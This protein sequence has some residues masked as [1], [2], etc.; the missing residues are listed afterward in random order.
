MPDRSLSSRV[1]RASG[2]LLRRLTIGLGALILVFYFFGNWILAS[3]PYPAC[4]EWPK[5]SLANARGDVAEI[6]VRGCILGLT[7]T[8][9]I[10]S[11]CARRGARP[12]SLSCVSSRNNRPRCI[13]ST[14]STCRRISTKSPQYRLRSSKSDRSMSLSPLA[15]PTLPWIEAAS[16]PIYEAQQRFRA[17]A[18]V[19][20]PVPPVPRVDSPEFRGAQGQPR[21]EYRVLGLSGLASFKARHQAFARRGAGRRR[22]RSSVRS[23]CARWQ[24]REPLRRHRQARSRGPA[25]DPALLAQSPSRPD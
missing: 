18:H 13:G 23:R 8:G 17:I 5:S 19:G 10:L 11:A 16:P 15:A 24:D 22:L 2:R 20:F 12:P 7:S 21:F 14:Q 4:S 3:W 9:N 6:A 25:A 1:L